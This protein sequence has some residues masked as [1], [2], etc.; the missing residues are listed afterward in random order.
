MYNFKIFPQAIIAIIA[1]FGSFIF[2]IALGWS[3][4]AGPKLLD[5]DNSFTI[6]KSD[7]AFAASMISLGG[8]LASFTSGL[9]RNRFGT[10]KSI[11]IFSIPSTIGW[12][13]LVFS[14]N[15]WMVIMGRFFIGFATGGY[16]FN[17]LTY[18]GEISSKQI[19]G[20]LL[21]FYEIN[22]KVGVLFVYILGTVTSLLVM[23]II[24]TAIVILYAFAFVALPETPMYLMI[25]GKTEEAKK[26]L[27][28]LR[29]NNYNCDAEMTEIQEEINEIEAT[30]LSFAQEIKKKATR[31]AFIM[32]VI[33]FFFFQMSGINAVLFYMT[34][35][36]IE[37]GI[38]FDPFIATA[39]LGLIQL[40][41]IISST[42]FVDHYGRKILMILSNITMIFGLVGMGV[43]F[44][45]KNTSSVSGFEF[46]TLVFL[47]IFLIGFSFGVGS[48]TFVLVGELFSLNAKK[49]VSSLAQGFSFLMSFVV[50]TF[51]PSVADAIGIQYTFYIFATFCFMATIYLIIFLPETKGKSLYEIQQLLTNENKSIKISANI[52]FLL[53]GVSL[54]WSSVVGP[55]I[56][57]NNDFKFWIQKKEFGIVVGIMSFGA[58]FSAVI[59]GIIRH[60][61]GTRKT[62]LIFS[63]PSTLGYIF[64]TISWNLYTLILGRFLIGISIGCYSFLVPI[65]VGEIS[66]NKNRGLMLGLLHIL[67]NFGILFIYT[68]GYFTSVKTLNIVCAS[69]PLF[70][71]TT[72]Y[73]LPESPIYLQSK[74]KHDL[75]ENASILLRGDSYENK[76][77]KQILKVEKQS[78]RD[79]VKIKSIRKAL[80]II[81]FQFFCFQLAGGNAVV[82]YSLQIFI[83]AQIQIEPIFAA[84][85]TSSL[86]FI[87]SFFAAFYIRKYG[88][89]TMLCIFNTFLVLSLI[90]LGFYFLMK[91]RSSSFIQDF[92]W[93]PLISLC[94]YLIAFGLGMAPITYIWFGELFTLDA[95]K[96]IA[97]LGQ[98]VNHMLTFIVGLLFPIL[99]EAIGLS[100]LFFI[101]A[102]ITTID[103]IFVIV[104]VPET[105]G[106]SVDEIQKLLAQ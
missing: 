6:P 77:T 86:Q 23:N 58:A 105:F 61:I 8:F 54:A 11:V 100:F 84:L 67:L 63:I 66:S 25:K 96:T 41:A 90:A 45:I 79:L 62:I 38:T 12:L 31:K 3:A 9:I 15:S 68:L 81:I 26:S 103:I 80:I 75:T 14:Q 55:Q 16:S 73:A 64:L 83:D 30:K 34:T 51:F 28:I 99:T 7:I 104:F 82:F 102:T 33:M 52:G 91:E 5:E 85:I 48:V 57:Q 69:I 21:T 2:G 44:H 10:I 50:A 1:S 37:S 43:Y 32:V 17:C 46:L 97:P 98:V 47:C 20:I 53:F 27:K 101:F 88:R 87:G 106:K 74:C 56:V 76:S 93:L 94:I 18:I 42:F 95:K 92:R 65:Y 19:R 70:Y 36:L 59:S 35:I 49:V 13:L 4:P 60:N 24:I 22:V 72:F 29:G 78:F 40:I 39:I 71:A 89:K